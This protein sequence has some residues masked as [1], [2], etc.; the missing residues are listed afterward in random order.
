M[1]TEQRRT[2]TL[3]LTVFIVLAVLLGQSLATAARAD[4][5]LS[6]DACL[7]RTGQEGIDACAELADDFGDNIFRLVAHGKTLERAGRPAAALPMYQAAATHDPKDKRALQG[8]IRAR[9]NARA[10]RIILDI[11]PRSSDTSP[12]WTTR[13]MQA[14]DACRQETARHPDDARLQERLGDVARSVGDVTTAQAAYARSLALAPGN[15]NL[16]RKRGALIRLM[17]GSKTPSREAPPPVL[18][19]S[20]SGNSDIA[21][22]HARSKAPSSGTPPPA[23]VSNDPG[24]SDT[25]RQLQLLESLRA[26]GLV[27]ALEYQNRRSSLLAT[28]FAGPAQSSPQATRYRGLHGG[29]YFAVVIGNDSYTDFPQ[30]LTATADAKAVSTLLQAR[31]GFEVTTLINADR[32]QIMSALSDLR[33]TTTKDDN[34][35]LYYAGH[36]LLDEQADRGYWLP[37]DANHAN[38]AQWISTSDIAG[39]FAGA[40]AK[41]A[42]VIADSCFA[43]TLLRTAGATGLETLERLAAKRSRTVLTSGG[44]E[45]VIDDGDGTHSVFAAALLDALTV[46]DTVLEASKLFTA[47]RDRVVLSADQTP[48]YSPMQKA[49]HDGGDFLFIPKTILGNNGTH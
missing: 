16:H 41:H 32:F 39:I 29:R 3:R 42:L 34:L 18:V 11:A 27:S 6:N 12:C 23:S 25:V 45:P 8:L 35:L 48:Q 17:A 2:M 20:Q 33:R 5:P 36:G 43:G 28:A 4:A 47:V 31:Y 40:A 19:S 1:A 24:N 10:Q 13:W 26:K 38:M 22:Q 9:A 44:L 30:L 14:L 49:G 15:D 46:N 21:R 37:V 7:S